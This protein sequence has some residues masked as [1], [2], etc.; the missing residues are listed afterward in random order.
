MSPISPGIG[1][2][3]DDAHFWFQ[4]SQTALDII[5]KN[6]DDDVYD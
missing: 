1:K 3:R 4:A 6:S 2:H 5:W